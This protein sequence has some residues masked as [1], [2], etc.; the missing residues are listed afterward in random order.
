MYNT[1]PHIPSAPP[2][3]TQ[4]PETEVVIVPLSIYTPEK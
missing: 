4:G 1:Q 2:S 3:Y